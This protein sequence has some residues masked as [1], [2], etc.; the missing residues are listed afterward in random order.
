MDQRGAHLVFDLFITESGRANKAGKKVGKQKKQNRKGR[1]R[2]RKEGNG[3]GG[4]RKVNIN[5][6]VKSIMYCSLERSGERGVRGY[7]VL[8]WYE[9]FFIL[10]P[11]NGVRKTFD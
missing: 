11:Q 8:V 5:H 10:S 6:V 2:R 7:L 3:L 4:G 9:L 1:Q